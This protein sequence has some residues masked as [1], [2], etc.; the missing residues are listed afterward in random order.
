M[1]LEA[2]DVTTPAAF[3]QATREVKAAMVA[4]LN[5]QLVPEGEPQP[6][7]RVPFIANRAIVNADRGEPWAG[8]LRS[9]RHVEGGNRK[10]DTFGVAYAGLQTREGSRVGRK[11]FTLRF[12]IFSYVEDDVGTN[13]DNAEEFQNEQIARVVYALYQGRNLGIGGLV[14]KL[15]DFRERR[16]TIPMGTT[17]V[18]QSLGE[19]FVHLKPVPVDPLQD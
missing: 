8:D 19:V 10:V 17:L 7:E 16:G 15:G 1:A 14:D 3:A 2:K 9:A 12:V 11:G 18:K 13:A 5:A 6:G 4:L